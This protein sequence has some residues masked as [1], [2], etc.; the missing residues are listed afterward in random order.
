MSNK[1]CLPVTACWSPMEAHA[2]AIQCHSG[3]PAIVQLP[4]PRLVSAST[5]HFIQQSEPTMRCLTLLALLTCPCFAQQA[6]PWARTA[7]RATMQPGSLTKASAVKRT[8]PVQR[9]HAPEVDP[10]ALQI[11]VE[12]RTLMARPEDFASMKAGRL[13]RTPPVTIKPKPPKVSDE[14]LQA[15][16]G[17]RLVSAT[18]VVEERQP[19]FVRKLS[20]KEAFELLSAVQGDERVN[21]L[22]APK[23]TLFDGQEAEITDVTQRPFA[24][25]L[26]RK[27]NT[28]QPVVQLRDE[29]VRTAVRG[30][31][32][33][34]KVRLDL[35]IT[36]SNIVGVETRP[37]GTRGEQVQVPK[38]ELDKVQLAALVRDG[39]TLAVCG[40]RRMREVRKVSNIP[41]I[42]KLFKNVSIAREPEEIVW[43]ITPRII[44]QQDEAEPNLGDLIGGHTP[45]ATQPLAERKK[46]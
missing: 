35:A 21:M 46:R 41:V 9:R 38:V 27:D 37:G 3:Q 10:N 45:A 20:D 33:D 31:V 4:D 19:V 14:E 15:S 1:Q 26:T 16:G 34:G 18:R 42:S 28:L 23:V 6:T 44:R 5:C 13:V 36:H 8:E 39:G 25:G 11:C 43:L 29:G 22:F 7:G 32:V 30:K 12:F 24:V 17:I 2:A 40:F